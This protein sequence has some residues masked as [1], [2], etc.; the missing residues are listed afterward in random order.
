MCNRMLL[1]SN[2]INMQWCSPGMLTRGALQQGR[3][4][5][6]MT[7]PP[8]PRRQKNFGKCTILGVQ[9]IF[10]HIKIF[11]ELIQNLQNLSHFSLL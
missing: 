7:P 5:F 2:N 4:F 10:G 11:R 6:L 9:K 8:P 3:K 1:M